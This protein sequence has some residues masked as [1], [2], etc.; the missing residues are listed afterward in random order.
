[1]NEIGRR[2][3]LNVRIYCP[4]RIFK[5]DNEEKNRLG[6]DLQTLIDKGLKSECIGE[7]WKGKRRNTTSTRKEK[8][9]T[10]ANKKN[11]PVAQ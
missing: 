8:T 9:K 1:M 2:I 11:N 6:R 5:V 4:I 10:C 3:T 7:K